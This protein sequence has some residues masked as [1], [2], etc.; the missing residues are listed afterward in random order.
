[1][2]DIYYSIKRIDLA[3]YNILPVLF[4]VFLHPLRPLEPYQFYTL[5]IIVQGCCKSAFTAFSFFVNVYECACYLYI[6]AMRTDILY[7]NN[8]FTVEITIG[9]MIQQIF[10]SGYLQFFAQYLS[11]LRAN[12][13]QVFNRGV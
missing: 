4:Q 3:K 9:V 1:V 13:F 2:W 8:S 5:G 10:K 11:L 7:F 12:A 6:I